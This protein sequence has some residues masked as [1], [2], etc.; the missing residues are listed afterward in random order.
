MYILMK[1]KKLDESN[2]QQWFKKYFL[3]YLA[4]LKDKLEKK[5]K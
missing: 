1:E 3:N 2:K 5:Y 4:V